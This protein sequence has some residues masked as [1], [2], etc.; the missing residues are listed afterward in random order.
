[1]ASADA[2]KGKSA[3]IA[4]KNRHCFRNLVMI[5]VLVDDFNE[6]ACLLDQVL[7]ASL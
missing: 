5:C 4:V 7:I 1:M 2:I 3:A 6:Y